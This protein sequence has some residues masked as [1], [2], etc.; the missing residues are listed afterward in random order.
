M[1]QTPPM[2]LDALQKTQLRFDQLDLPSQEAFGR[3]AAEL[4]AQAERE[5]REIDG[6][7]TWERCRIKW[8]GRKDSVLSRITDNWLKPAPPEWKKVVGAALNLL[9]FKVDQDLD[10]RKLDIQQLE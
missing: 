7:E 3:L 2:S 8:L 5:F 10:N 4:E 6:P 1:S 9:R